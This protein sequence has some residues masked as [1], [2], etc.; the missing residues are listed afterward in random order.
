MEENHVEQI[1]E[2]MS[3]MKC[4]KD[5]ECYKSGF[6]N[7]CKAKDTGIGSF[8][9]CLEENSKGCRFFLPFG[10]TNTNLCMCPVRIQIL[11]NME[12]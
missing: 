7:L 12:K 1:E 9:E 2:I 10:N 4:P 3:R 11:R 6:K 8:A 5:F